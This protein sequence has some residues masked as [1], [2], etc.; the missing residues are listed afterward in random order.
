[1]RVFCVFSQGF[2]LAESEAMEPGLYT[3][4][5]NTYEPNLL[6]NFVLNVHSTAPPQHVRAIPPEGEGMAR[7]VCRGRRQHTRVCVAA[8][9]SLELAS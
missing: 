4:I 3:V 1:M 8:W 7:Q 9:L 5:V 2:C 6:G